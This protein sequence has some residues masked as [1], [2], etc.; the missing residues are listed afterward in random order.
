VTRSDVYLTS[1][2]A[3]A[4]GEA[5]FLDQTPAGWRISAAGCTPTKD[6]MPY[7]CELEN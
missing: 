1:G 2:F 7:D 5:A 3:E 6:D 4:G